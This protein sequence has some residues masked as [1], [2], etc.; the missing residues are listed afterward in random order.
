MLMPWNQLVSFL[1]SGIR[2]LRETD[3]QQVRYG[4]VGM[5][6]A[7]AIDVGVIL[8]LT[9]MRLAAMRK[10]HSRQHSGHVIRPAHR[11]RLW[12]RA[13]HTAPKAFLAAALVMLIFSVA[14]PFLTATEEVTGYVE[15]RVRIDLVDT[16]GSMALSLIHI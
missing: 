10:R 16:S 7:L 11:K 14:D 2:E 5:A 8:A 12:I 13:L 15:S 9:L 6:V 4:D 3:F 1:D